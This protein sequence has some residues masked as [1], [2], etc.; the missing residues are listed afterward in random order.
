MAAE[1]SDDW[2]TQME[3]DI[4]GIAQ[5]LQLLVQRV[6]RRNDGVL[7]SLSNPSNPAS[8]RSNPSP[9]HEVRLEPRP[10]ARLIKPASPNDFSGERRKGRAFS[11]CADSTPPPA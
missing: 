5:A 2:R 3:S 8:E 11:N 9:I 4:T 10:T 6:D 1:Q 7:P